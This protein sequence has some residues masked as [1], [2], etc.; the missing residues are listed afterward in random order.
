MLPKSHEGGRVGSH[1]IAEVRA[2]K[3]IK[4][5]IYSWPG[6]CPAELPI[7]EEMAEWTFKKREAPGAGGSIIQAELGRGMHHEV[8]QSR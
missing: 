5:D 7:A 1:W 8:R 3:V 4:E 2:G 6:S